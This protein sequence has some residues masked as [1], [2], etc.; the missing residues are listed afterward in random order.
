M[1]ESHDGTWAVCDGGGYE[2]HPRVFLDTSKSGV[3]VCP[4]CSKQVAVTEGKE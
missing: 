4:Y 1:Q 2:G 3:T